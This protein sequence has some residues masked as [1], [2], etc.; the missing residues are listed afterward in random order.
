MICLMLISSMIFTSGFLK[1]LVDLRWMPKDAQ[2]ARKGVLEP[3]F[4]CHNE[5]T[6]LILIPSLITKALRMLQASFFVIWLMHPRY[7]YV[8]SYLLSAPMYPWES[9]GK[10]PASEQCLVICIVE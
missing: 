5:S 7:Y 2:M 3:H 9:L 6:I 4:N 8:S 10:L 1:T